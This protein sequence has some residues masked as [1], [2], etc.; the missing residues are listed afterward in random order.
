MIVSDGFDDAAAEILLLLR[1][2]VP[3]PRILRHVA[4]HH[5]VLL[6][7]RHGRCLAHHPFMQAAAAAALPTGRARRRKR[8]GHRLPKR[9]RAPAGNEAEQHGVPAQHRL[10]PDWVAVL[11]PLGFGIG[12]VGGGG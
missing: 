9:T 6:R 5:P 11:E 7:G 1:L 12:V 3:E 2:Q 4:D 8:G 10:V